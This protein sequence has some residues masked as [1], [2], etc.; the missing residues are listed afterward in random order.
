MLEAV[1]VLRRAVY[2]DKG[3]CFILGERPGDAILGWSPSLPGVSMEGVVLKPTVGDAKKPWGDAASLR[4][5]DGPAADSCEY[6]IDKL[7]YIVGGLR[8]IR[9]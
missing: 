7:G 6:G 3:E 9:C 1:V 2:A 4:C 8:Y 5:L